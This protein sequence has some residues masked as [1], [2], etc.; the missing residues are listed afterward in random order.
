[1]IEISFEDL[2]DDVK[3]LLVV[4]DLLRTEEQIVREMILEA[5]DPIIPTGP[6]F[7]FE[8]REPS[9]FYISIDVPSPS[10]RVDLAQ[11]LEVARLDAVACRLTLEQ[12]HSLEGT[13]RVYANTIA[14]LKF[15]SVRYPNADWRQRFEF[16]L[17]VRGIGLDR[18]RRKA[19]A[20]FEIEML[21]AL[22]SV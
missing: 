8:P 21:Q 13:I 9:E 18:L 7:L 1:M 11:A 20:K 14:W 17:Q 2:D 6:L 15:L 4:S 12:D 3:D 22:E 19:R 10:A 16:E 5:I